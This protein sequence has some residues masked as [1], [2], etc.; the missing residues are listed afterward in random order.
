ML[1]LL[2]L[3]LACQK[4]DDGAGD[5][6]PVADCSP[7]DEICDEKDNDCDGVVDE[8]APEAQDFYWDKDMD[9]FGTGELQSACFPPEDSAATNDDCDDTNAEVYPGKRPELCNGLDDD[10]DGEIDPPTAQGAEPY[11]TDADG[12]GYG[13]GAVDVACELPEGTAGQDG[14]CDDTRADVYPG[15]VETWYDGVDGDCLRD[16]DYDADADG[17]DSMDYGGTDCME[18]DPSIT[19]CRPAATCTH[20]TAAMLD[21]GHLNVSTDLAFDAD[22]SALVTGLRGG[23]DYAFWMDGTGTSTT[24]T[25]YSEYDMQAVALS[26]LNGDAVVSHNNGGSTGLGTL[27]AGE[28]SISAYVGGKL[29][30]GNLWRDSTFNRNPSQLAW[31][32]SGC[33]WAPGLQNDGNLSCVSDTTGSVSNVLVGLEHIEAVALDNSEQLYI[34]V[35]KEVLLVDAAAGTTTLVHTAADDV[36]SLAFDPWLGD[37]YVSTNAKQIEKVPADGSASSVWQS[38]VSP[39]RIATSPDGWLIALEPEDQAFE[40]WQLPQY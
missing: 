20:P 13:V 14:D 1:T 18:E 17:A 30:Y 10:C 38:T 33:I 2:L 26:P 25:G 24:V 37:M 11:Y 5:S 31:D 21:L 27:T 12:D 22:C 39:A 19:E 32:S 28:V 9:G 7:R 36:L 34:G 6:D 3:A 29:S 40:E 23:V 8:E 4:S 15:N 35:E 16:N